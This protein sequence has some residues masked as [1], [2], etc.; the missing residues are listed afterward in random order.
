MRTLELE[1]SDKRERYQLVAM[2]GQMLLERSSVA[3]DLPTGLKMASEGPLLVLVLLVLR[4]LSPAES[5]DTVWSSKG[6]ST[7]TRSGA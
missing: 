2:D 7:A 1:R 6:V 3:E 4:F 5:V